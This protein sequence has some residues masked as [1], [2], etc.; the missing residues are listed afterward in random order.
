MKS[1][2]EKYKIPL[3]RGGILLS[4]IILSFV[5]N[6]GNS[7]QNADKSSVKSGEAFRASIAEDNQTEQNNQTGKDSQVKK[8]VWA[9]EDSQI[10]K[11]NQAEEDNQ[12]GKNNQTREDNRAKKD[13]RTEKDDQAKKDNVV[14]IQAKKDENTHEEEKNIKNVEN[15]VGGEDEDTYALEDNKNAKVKEEV[16]SA[17]TK[18]VSTGF[19]SSVTEE[20]Y[21]VKKGDTLFLIAQRANISVDYLMQLNNLYSDIIY[22]GQILKI[23][24]TANNSSNQIASRGG[25]RDEDLYWLSRIIHSEAQ[26]ESYRGKV[27]VGNVIINRADSGLFPNTI[28]GVVFDKQNGYTQFSPVIDGTIYNTPN[29]ESVN[30]AVEALNGTR[31]VGNALYFLNPRAS[32][33]FWIINNRKYMTTI[34]LHDFYY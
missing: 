17:Q 14:K 12:T 25:E 30:A 4:I 6:F 15:S 9:G 13:N 18:E 10:E 8:D 22:E 2:F 27:A 5:I 1:V 34:G 20:N 3:S 28:K 31:P 29:T 21:T 32:T 24:G 26:G 19:L 11:S 23:G 33:N 16:A 7:K